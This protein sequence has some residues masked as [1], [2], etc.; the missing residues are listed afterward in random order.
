MGKTLGDSK[1][2]SK[3]TLEKS[4]IQNNI[5]V[6]TIA[7][8]ILFDEEWKSE[9]RKRIKIKVTSRDFFRSAKQEN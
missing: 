9:K 4:K 6:I 8:K 5:I 2:I 1:E 7:I 3:G